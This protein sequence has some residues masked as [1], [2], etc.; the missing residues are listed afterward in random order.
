MTC[1]LVKDHHGHQLEV[2]YCRLTFFVVAT[3]L[4]GYD[5]KKTIISTLSETMSP[6]MTSFL[7][8]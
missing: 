8:T 3:V 5:D 4:I 1:V 7:V 6:V 2:G